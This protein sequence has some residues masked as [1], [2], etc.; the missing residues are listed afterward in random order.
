MQVLQML[1]P[2]LGGILLVVLQLTLHDKELR[3]KL[4][5][6]DEASVLYAVLHAVSK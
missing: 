5:A 6:C 2:K 4:A 1:A 3:V